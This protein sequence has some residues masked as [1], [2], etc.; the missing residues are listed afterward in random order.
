MRWSGV[1]AISRGMCSMP[2]CRSKVLRTD[3]PWRTTT[4]KA[5]RGCA[6]GGVSL[7]A[8][9]SVVCSGSSAMERRSAHRLGLHQLPD[10]ALLLPPAADRHRLAVVGVGDLEA[11]AV[12]VARLRDDLG[13]RRWPRGH[14]AVLLE[15]AERLRGEIA[16]HAGHVAGYNVVR[17]PL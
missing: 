11:L 10:A 7:E 16:D 6:N 14:H 2:S 9:A 4:S 15:L 5:G 8:A 1:V 3:S 17:M 12:A 13:L